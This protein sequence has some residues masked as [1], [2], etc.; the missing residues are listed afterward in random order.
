MKKWIEHA[1][2]TFHSRLN[3]DTTHLLITEDAWR[4]QNAVVLEAF[5]AMEGGQ[6]IKL[7]RF[8]WLG[9]CVSKKRKMSEKAYIWKGTPKRPK[10]RGASAIWGRSNSDPEPGTELR[11]VKGLM[12]EVFQDST[13]R[14]VDDGEDSD[15]TDENAS[16]EET[17]VGRKAAKEVRMSR[18]EQEA[19]FG[20]GAKKSKYRNFIGWFMNI[21]GVEYK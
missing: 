18:E 8:G 12:A 4:A 5:E 13:E 9:D 14:Y 20:R 1:G 17:D 3:D 6:N 2:G 21:S 19:L 7:V 11:S 15:E 16:G 10:K